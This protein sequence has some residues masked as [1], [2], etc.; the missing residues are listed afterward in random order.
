[1]VGETSAVEKRNENREERVS[2]MPYKEWPFR[3]PQ[4]TSNGQETVSFPV[5]IYETEEE[6]VIAGEIPGVTKKDVQ[7]E[8]SENELTITGHFHVGL[9]SEERPSFYEIP[10]AD[11]H[12]TFTLSEAVNRE[13]ITAGLKDGLLTLRLGKSESI[14]PRKIEISA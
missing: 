2:E 10:G 6:F 7:V 5:D 13:K 9:D 1:M 11:Y 12:R 4:K 8:I 3:S 14:K